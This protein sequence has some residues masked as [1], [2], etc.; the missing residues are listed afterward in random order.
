MSFNSYKARLQSLGNNKQTSERAI[1]KISAKN[2]ILNSPSL[3]KVYLEKQLVDC[4]VSDKTN[5]EIRTFLFLPDTEIYK[6]NYIEHQEQ[7]YITIDHTLDDIYPQSFSY[8]CNFNFPIKTE[9]IKT[10]VGYTEQ[11]RPKYD[12][13]KNVITKPCAFSNKEFSNIKNESVSLPNGN[14]I[15]YIQ[16]STNPEENPKI[17]QEIKFREYK[18][19]IT[20]IRYDN[21]LLFKGEEKGY[22]EIRLQREANSNA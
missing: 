20:D 6:G 5:Y 14:A 15:V 12:T 7:T 21:I 2:K 16:Y 11:G 22:L 18:Y 19:K 1:T 17:N 4:I 9:E 13:Q 8:L 3:S 10:I